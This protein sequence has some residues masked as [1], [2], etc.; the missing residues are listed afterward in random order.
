MKEEE[1]WGV[2]GSHCRSSS[3]E[4]DSAEMCVQEVRW[5]VVSPW[6]GSEME[7]RELLSCSVVPTRDSA[8]RMK[9]P[10]ELSELGQGG[11]A[12]LL[13]GLLLD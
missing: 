5:P 7:Q 11:W 1:I 9:E 8:S 13:S 2:R 12:G 6:G 10:P 4:A 3:Q